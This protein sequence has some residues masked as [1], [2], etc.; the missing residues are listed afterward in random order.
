MNKSTPAKPGR[1]P[2]NLAQDA[3]SSIVDAACI[4][5]SQHGVKGTTNRQIAEEAKVTAAMVHYYFK[6]KSALHLGVLQAA[7]TPLLDS[8][9][10]VTSLEEWVTTFHA[11]LVERPWLP[12]LMIREVL[13]TSGQLRPLFMKNFAP[14]IFGSIKAMVAREAAIRKV[15]ASFDLERHIVLLMGMLVYP[16]MTMEIAHSLTGR[17]FD[18]AMFDGFRDDAF[19]LFCKG[20]SN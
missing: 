12:H 3:S 18:K 14:H 20:I 1:P 7:F 11:H 19:R 10:G 6:T 15:D 9:T 2:Q 8:L 17:K 4:H 16:F 5:F 13:S